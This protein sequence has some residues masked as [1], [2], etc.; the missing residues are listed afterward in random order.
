MNRIFKVIWSKTKHCYVVVSEY[1]KA[2]TKAAHTGVRVT[3]AAL[4]AAAVLLA[5]VDY[6]T[7]WAQTA[8]I[9]V[10]STDGNTK[11]DVYTKDGADSKFA[12]WDEV[13]N[14]ADK[15]DVQQETAA[16]EAKDNELNERIT[17]EA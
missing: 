4:A 9:E 8:T 15:T 13:K 6:S 5:P 17:N 11:T 3:A 1:A 10:A 12:T 14:K 7:V 2:N 16:R